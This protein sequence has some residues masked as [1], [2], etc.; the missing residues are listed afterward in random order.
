[1]RVTKRESK[2][3]GEGQKISLFRPFLRRYIFWQIGFAN[4]SFNSWYKNSEKNLWEPLHSKPTKP[5]VPIRRENRNDIVLNWIVTIELF[6]A[7]LCILQIIIKTESAINI[8]FKNIPCYKHNESNPLNDNK[9]RV[10]P[11]PWPSKS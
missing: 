4:F 2:N 10:G 1:M 3:I 5:L 11:N 6:S 9:K 8:Y 7:P